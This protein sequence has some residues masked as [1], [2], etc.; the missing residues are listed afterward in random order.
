MKIDLTI[1]RKEGKQRMSF[2]F[3][4]CW[5]QVN[6]RQYIELIKCKGDIIKI[7][8]LFTKLDEDMIRN[9]KIHNLSVITACLSFLSEPPI[10]MVPS[11]ILCYKI[12]SNL[13][14]ESIAQYAD[15][16]TIAQSFVKDDLIHNYNLFPIIV[17]T[18]AVNPYNYNEAER[19]KDMFYDAPCTEVLA[20]GNFTLA[21]LNA[22]KNGIVPTS[23]P[24]ATLLNRLMLAM[25]NWLET[26][27]STLRYFLWKR[28]L[29]LNERN[30]LNGL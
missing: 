27:A 15:I 1:T 12:A 17:A 5:Q 30:Y 23:P 25:R 7:V 19:I 28:S 14:T 13:E 26:M 22:L 10:Y 4:T 20:V 16:Q 3:P 18:Y 8:S 9:A 2:D 24:A 29:P 21:R 6:F 11:K